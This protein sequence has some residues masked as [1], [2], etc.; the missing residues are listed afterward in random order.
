MRLLLWCV[1][2]ASSVAVPAAAQVPTRTSLSLDEALEIARR[3]NPVY[4]QSITGRTRAS[5]AVRSA[6]GALLPSVDASLG[7][8]Y[9]EG[10]PQFFGGVAFGATSDI[11]SSS[12]G[13]SASSRLSLNTFSDI[14]P[15]HHHFKTLVRAR[16]ST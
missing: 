11:I 8:S 2:V 7:A 6:W 4:L 3:N 16:R 14:N 15:C 10:R 1:L 9:R 12:W 5:A 13:L